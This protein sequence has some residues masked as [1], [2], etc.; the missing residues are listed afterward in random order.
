MNKAAWNR[1]GELEDQAQSILVRS[2]KTDQA[3][4]ST[5]GPSILKLTVL[6]I[7]GVLKQLK[8]DPTDK[9]KVTSGS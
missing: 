8:Y 7:Q 9:Q 2:R 6:K 4:F 3:D 1:M 5:L